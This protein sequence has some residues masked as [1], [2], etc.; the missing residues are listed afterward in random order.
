MDC[1]VSLQQN[2][3]AVDLSRFQF[4]MSADT[5]IQGI[6]PNLFGQMQLQFLST[7]ERISRENAVMHYDIAELYSR[8]M[9]EREQEKD[10]W[11]QEALTHITEL[12]KYAYE[13]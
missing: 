4:N 7:V 11:Q 5:Y 6:D 1:S 12:H 8:M 13:R 9:Q 10:L 3:I 2:N